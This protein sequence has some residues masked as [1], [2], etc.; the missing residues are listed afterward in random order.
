MLPFCSFCDHNV[1][2]RLVTKLFQ[3]T[4]RF[5]A[6]TDILRDILSDS[7]GPCKRWRHLH[8]AVE[9]IVALEKSIGVRLVFLGAKRTSLWVI[10]VLS[11]DVALLDREAN[12]FSFC[13]RIEELGLVGLAFCAVLLQQANLFCELCHPCTFQGTLGVLCC[14]QLVWDH[15]VVL[16]LVVK[17]FVL[18]RLV[19][20][21][22]ELVLSVIVRFCTAQIVPIAL[23]LLSSFTALKR[24]SSGSPSSWSCH[25]LWGS[26]WPRPRTQLSWS[27]PRPRT[28]FSHQSS[29]CIR[30][31]AGFS[32]SV[33]SWGCPGV[34]LISAVPLGQ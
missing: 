17:I 4:R 27:C 3:D 9:H 8:R 5:T 14:G 22:F 31:C 11:S 33:G 28:R 29:L 1:A 30:L 7:S 19:A 32:A 26:S 18:L 21:T 10:C 25:T 34:R 24:N 2:V 6:L 20:Y 23:Q 12:C 15:V 16:P 13:D